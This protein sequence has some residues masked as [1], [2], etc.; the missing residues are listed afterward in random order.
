MKYTLYTSRVAGAL[1]LLTHVTSVAAAACYAAGLLTAGVVLE[2]VLALGCLG[3]GILLWS[4]LRTVAPVRSATFALLRALEAS[5]ILAGT[6]PMT[7]LILFPSSESQNGALLDQLHTASF[8]VGQGLV[9]AVNTL[10]LGSL[11][12]DTRAVPRTLAV[13]GLA[14]GAIVLASDIAQLTGVIP[15]NGI[16]AGVCAVPI[17]AFEIWFAILLLVRGIRV[18]GAAAA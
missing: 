7:A 16:V 10:V 14:G 1:Y 11:L 18:G 5:V 9:I 13:L 4:L 15:L 12:F 8:L 2:F 17:F 6:L 3:T